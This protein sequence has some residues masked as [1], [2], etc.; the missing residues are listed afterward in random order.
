M[1]SALLLPL[2]TLPVACGGAEGGS[3]AG[4]ARRDSS[5]VAIVENSAPRW[6][7]G[8]AWTVAA[9]PLLRGRMPAAVMQGC[10]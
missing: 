2:L 3:A 7:A 1:R 4:P 5:G 9:T 10:A 6:G 8:E